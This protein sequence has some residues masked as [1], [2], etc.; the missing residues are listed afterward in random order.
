[1]QKFLGLQL[2]AQIKAIK[3]HRLRM[4]SKYPPHEGTIMAMMGLPIRASVAHSLAGIHQCNHHSNT[5][6]STWI[7]CSA[8]GT[9]SKSRGSSTRITS[10]RNV[11]VGVGRRTLIGKC[12]SGAVQLYISTSSAVKNECCPFLPVMAFIRWLGSMLLYWQQLL[13]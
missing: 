7:A 4:A 8:G 11:S 2:S 13:S 5:H 9:H 6:K 1:L 12:I 10:S 3:L